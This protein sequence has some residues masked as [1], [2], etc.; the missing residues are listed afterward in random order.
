MGLATFRID[1][2]QDALERTDA[3]LVR[4]AD[5][6]AAH[7]R[8]GALVEA[9][10]LRALVAQADGD[11]EAATVS[12]TAALH[13]AE[14][15]GRRAVFVDEGP[16]MAR[17][18]HVA[19][20]R[21]APRAFVRQLLDDLRADGERPRVRRDFVEPLSDRERDVLRL[22]RGSL[23]GPQVARELGMSVHTLRS[24]T[25][26]VYAKLDVHGRREAVARAVELGLV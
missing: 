26:S 17:L 4:V 25:K 2:K 6:A 20:Q 16:A 10:V 24:H 21:G 5:A 19:L 23:T 12:L 14:P 18:L 8:S 13:Q 3:L 9:Q 11:L 7:G 22:L 1:G 15:E